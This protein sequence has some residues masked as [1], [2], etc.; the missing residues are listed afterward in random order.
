MYSFI[1]KRGQEEFILQPAYVKKLSSGRFGLCSKEEAE[2]IAVKGRMLDFKDL[3]EVS[4]AEYQEYMAKQQED[5]ITELEMAVAQLSI[6]AAGGKAE[7]LEGVANAWGNLIRKGKIK[8]EEVPDLNGL[9][10]EVQK[11]IKG[12]NA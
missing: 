8:A 4:D 2:G 1:N 10:E 5:K 12:D 6:I 3:K 7:N 11:R 9:K